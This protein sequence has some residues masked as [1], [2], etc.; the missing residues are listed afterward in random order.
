MNKKKSFV[1]FMAGLAFYAFCIVGGMLP[2][3]NGLEIVNA[4]EA[5]TPSKTTGAEEEI[6]EAVGTPKSS[7]MKVY[8]D[9]ET[10]EF[11]A[12]PSKEPSTDKK[13]APE[14]AYSTSHEGLVETPSETPGG[15][16]MIDLQDRFRT[17]LTATRDIDGNLII[18]HQA[19]EWGNDKKE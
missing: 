4:E 19:G 7:A 13:R 6:S 12:S 16:M 11:I 8:I 15:G 14:A 17:P 18:Q 10:G 3:V 2:I 1:L 5:L 9:P